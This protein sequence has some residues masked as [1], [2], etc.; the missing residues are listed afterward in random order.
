MFRLTL[1]LICAIFAVLVIVPG[2]RPLA[3]PDPDRVEVTSTNLRPDT[4]P[5]EEGQGFLADVLAVLEGEARTPQPPLH[6]RSDT[7]TTAIGENADGEMTLTTTE[8]E[9]LLIAA[10]V[11]PSDLPTSEDGVTRVSV[12]RPEVAP[13]DPTDTTDPVAAAAEAEP[14]SV[15][16]WRVA[17]TE[18]N[19]R[20]GPSTDDA[21]LTSLTQGDEVEFLSEAGDGWAHLRVRA[22]GQEGYMSQQFLERVN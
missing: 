7:R 13:T 10:V 14:A 19:F 20:A 11:N 8:G 6:R 5:D 1:T 12:A 4:L 3:T 15:E 22:T 16:L 2:E 21:I 9:T 18:V 17:A